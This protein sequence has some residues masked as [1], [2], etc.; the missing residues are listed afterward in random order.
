[1]L[2]VEPNRK[3]L[4]A[5]GLAAGGYLR[6]ALW[7]VGCPGEL[8]SHDLLDLGRVL[9]DVDAHGFDPFKS[10]TEPP[11]GH[12]GVEFGKRLQKCITFK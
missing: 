11:V 7:I 9:R 2:V 1:M 3:W 8:L 5:K 10:H 12:L 4:K 6:Q